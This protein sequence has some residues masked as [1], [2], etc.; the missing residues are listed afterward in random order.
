[1]RRASESDGSPHRARRRGRPHELHGVADADGAGA[2]DLGVERE[3]PVEASD[4]VLQHAT[5][6]LE[7]VGID[8]GHRAAAA[9][10]IERDDHVTDVELRTRPTELFSSLDAVDDD[11][12]SQP[13]DIATER[14]DRAVGG[15]EQREDVEAL[16]TVVASE[17][18]VFPGG[19]TDA[20][21]HIF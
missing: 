17:D 2:E 4:D 1:M 15:D 7:R 19:G 13:A 18:R 20:I 11:V 6:D 10:R 9:T 8:R 5:I 12:R 21:E 16:R 3:L 14:G